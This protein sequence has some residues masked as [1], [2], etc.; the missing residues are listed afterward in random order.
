[1]ALSEKLQTDAD[2]TLEKTK[3]LVRQKEAAA[4]CILFA[5]S[6]FC[7]ISL[8]VV[9]QRMQMQKMSSE[10]I[11]STRSQLAAVASHATPRKELLNTS[12]KYMLW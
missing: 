12:S 2:L 3:R 8:L 11:R 4:C 6:S 10:S 7:L 1:M 5:A 9:S